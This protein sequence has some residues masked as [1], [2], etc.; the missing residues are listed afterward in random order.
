[1]RLLL[2]ILSVLLSASSFAQ[3][4]NGGFEVNM[5]GWTTV[6]GNVTRSTQVTVGNW[7]IVPSGAGMARI[8]PSGPNNAAAVQTTL[9]LTGNQL[10]SV[11]SITNVGA[12]YQDIVLTAGQSF[13]VYWN[14]VS[15]DYAPY[16]DGT[17]MSVTGPSTQQLTMLA[18]TQSNAQVPAV[19]SYGSTGWKSITYTATTSGTFR[20]GFGSFNWGDGGVHPILFLDNAMGGTAAPGMAIVTA[21]TAASNITGNSATTGGTISGD[22]GSAITERGVVYSTSATPTTTNTKVTSAGTTGTFNVNLTNLTPATTYYVRAYA[23]NAAG[24]VYGPEITFTTTQNSVTLTGTISK[25]AGVTPSLSLY[26]VVSNVE[27]L[28]ETRNTNADGTYSFIVDL[29]STYKLVPSLTVQG[30]TSADF[31]LVWLENQNES[32]PP[33]TAAGLVMTGTKQWKAADVNKNGVLD[34][35]DAYLISAHNSGFRL[36]TEVLWFTPA[37]YDSITRLNFGSVNPVTFFTINVTTSNVTQN[38][39]Y[40]I[41]GDVNL[42]HSSN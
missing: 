31:D 8:E 36:I 15:Q 10:S 3:I 5:A 17:F 37:N 24:T 16:D 22:G 19:Q 11:P 27:T 18:R 21:T 25:P 12:M 41:L 40:C 28:I 14:Y 13:T 30:I 6:A 39:K 26:K 1:V 33:V 23:I 20:L 35:G 32:T 38:I 7:T 29:N 34:L 9:G 2:V 42:S 4:T